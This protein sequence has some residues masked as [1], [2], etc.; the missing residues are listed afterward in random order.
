[1][2]HRHDH[3]RPVPPRRG[4]R[5]LDRLRAVSLAV[6]AGVALAACGGGAGGSGGGF[7]DT[8]GRDSETALL[9][10]ARCMR[11]HGVDMPDP[12]TEGGDKVLIGAD[13]AVDR[14]RFEEADNACRHLL[15]GT[16]REAPPALDAAVQDAFLKYARCMREHGIDHP[17]PDEGGLRI[18]IGQGGLDPQSPEFKEADKACRHLLAEVDE[19]LERSEP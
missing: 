16:A 12:S 3:G 9:E 7:A 13:P 11:D 4:G 18:R 2:R 17:D 6:L 8:G 10:F 19:K 14:E 5:G 1:M 15:D